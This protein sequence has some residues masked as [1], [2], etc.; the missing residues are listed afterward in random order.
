MNNEHPRQWLYRK[1]ISELFSIFTLGWG[2]L[3]VL[4]LVKPGVVSNYLSL[5]HLAI[6]LIFL[7]IWALALQQPQSG[8]SM[9]GAS[10]SKHERVI[11]TIISLILSI[12]IMLI[13]QVSFPLTLLLILV[14]VGT[15]WAGT[16]E[17][18]SKP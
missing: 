10:L 5:Q 3:F 1:M 6:G 8:V 16:I 4:E 11:L 14:T 12:V 18:S 7:G 2:I 15:L 13:T 9:E 17:F